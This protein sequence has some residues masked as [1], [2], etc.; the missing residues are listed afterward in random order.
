M[1]INAIIYRKLPFESNWVDIT[2]KIT[3]EDIDI[4][5]RINGSGICNLNIS[6][7]SRWGQ[8]N[9]RPGFQFRVYLKTTDG[10][11]YWKPDFE[12]TVP[13]D[14]V[15]SSV[16][17]SS[18]FQ[19]P[20][21]GYYAL[22][23]T[24]QNRYNLAG[25]NP[26]SAL[27]LLN[28]QV[29]HITE[30]QYMNCSGELYDNNTHLDEDFESDSNCKGIADRIRSILV[31]DIDPI[32]PRFTHIT[33]IY[34]PV[35][36]TLFLRREPDI[37]GVPDVIINEGNI[38]SVS[39]DDTDTFLTSCI[40]GSDDWNRRYT[41][42]NF[43]HKMAMYD[44]DIRTSEDNGLESSYQKTRELIRGHFLGK[45]IRVTLPGNWQIP[46]LSL[47]KFNSSEELLK[48]NQIVYG[49]RVNRSVSIQTELT[50]RNLPE[51]VL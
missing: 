36:P 30:G 12:G 44:S 26:V 43:A 11:L 7:V 22:Y 21:V 40:I 18:E 2:D 38:L 35:K 29:A 49:R 47:V 1:S 19:L 45:S 28:E 32:F 5:E 9:I 37:N 34:N 20:L 4:E 8:R 25:M 6:N 3:V 46:L 39:D 14:F 13:S 50:L 17:V 31:D 15:S 42:R 24:V 48:G 23:Q 41:N 10:R 33:T 51:D 16:S 27:C